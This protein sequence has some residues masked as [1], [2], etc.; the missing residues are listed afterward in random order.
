MS[1]TKFTPSEMEVILA[2]PYTEDVR[3][4]TIYYSLA[5]K[6]YVLREAAR[7]MTSVKIFRNAGYDVEILGKARIY[8]AMRSFKAEAASPQGLHTS[9]H[10][11]EARLAAAAKIDLSK[12]K[13]DTAIREMQE[14]I[15]HLEQQV[16]FL[17]KT[18]LIDRPPG[19]N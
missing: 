1:N 19:E 10:S 13:T 9:R 5:F 16:A 14:R 4:T 17:K 15:I 7:G 3:P 8:A 2:N 18:A 11:R 12:Q 6:E